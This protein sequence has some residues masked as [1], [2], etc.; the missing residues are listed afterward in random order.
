MTLSILPASG[1]TVKLS[2]A[3]AAAAKQKARGGGAPPALK[4]ED[5][6]TAG[7]ALKANASIGVLSSSSVLLKIEVV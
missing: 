7:T 5:S 3:P 6:L 1:D 4:R 2:L